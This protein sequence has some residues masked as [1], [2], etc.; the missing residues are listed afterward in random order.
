MT[1]TQ[2]EQLVR[3]MDPQS[4]LL[5]HWTLTGGISAQITALELQRADGQTTKM[6]VR[7]HGT[8]DLADNPRIAADEFRLLSVLQAASLA[9]PAPYYVDESNEIFET[10]VIIIEFIDGVT[11][12]ALASLTDFIHQMA[13]QLA[14]IHTLKAAEHDLAFLPQQTQRYSDRL[15]ALPAV[16]DDSLDEGRIRDILGAVWPLPPRNAPVLLHGDYWPGNILWKENQLSAVIDW[17]DA[18]VGDPLA[19][20]GNMRMELLWTLGQ[21][22]MQQFTEDYRRLTDIDFTHLPY[23]DLC[24]ALRPASRIGEWAGDPVKEAHMRECHQAFRTQAYEALSS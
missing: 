11:E 6:I 12:F 13:A 17:E 1:H 3:R 2:F 20:V 23:W 7:Q 8:G 10:P 18:G 5:R 19:D 14:R 15:Q 16:L 4:T 9:T 24:A 21:E 22:A